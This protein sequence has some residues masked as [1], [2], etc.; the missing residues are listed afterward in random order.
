MGGQESVDPGS[1]GGALLTVGQL[2]AEMIEVAQAAGSRPDYDQSALG[3]CTANAI[4][5]AI[6]F[7]QMKQRLADEFTPARLFI[8]YNERVESSRYNSQDPCRP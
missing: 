4:A 7:D 6:E 3:S 8:Y 2:L 1:S 5:G